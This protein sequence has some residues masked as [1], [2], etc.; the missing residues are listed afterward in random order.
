M[1]SLLGKITDVLQGKADWGN[2]P[3]SDK[4]P[5]VRKAYLSNHGSCAACGGNVKLEVHHMRTFHLH[6]ELELDP[7]NFITLCESGDNGL[8]CHLL[9]G[10]LG[11]F[12]SFNQ[13]VVADAAAWKDKIT[14]RPKEDK[15]NG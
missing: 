8:N 10:H 9:V 6:P 2:A 15:S 11:N 4:W 1:M 5:E 7:T 14:T 3:R 12:K 13:N